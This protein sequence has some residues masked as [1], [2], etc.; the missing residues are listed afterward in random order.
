MKVIWIH[1]RGERAREGAR[2]KQANGNCVGDAICC[3]S[4]DER[5]GWVDLGYLQSWSEH[6]DAGE[7]WWV[8][9][10]LQ[11]WVI[12]GGTVCQIKIFVHKIAGS[13]CLAEVSSVLTINDGFVWHPSKSC[14]RQSAGQWIEK[15]LFSEWNKLSSNS[16]NSS[17]QFNSPF[18]WVIF[19]A[20]CSLD[21]RTQQ[22]KVSIKISL[23]LACALDKR[24]RWR[25]YFAFHYGSDDNSFRGF[26][27]TLIFHKPFV[28]F[29]HLRI[30]WQ[31]NINC[32]MLPRHLYGWE[33]FD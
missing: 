30:S 5:W 14:F 32:R 11:S 22:R 6:N 4:D 33:W 23:M 28:S 31:L 16:H 7:S 1:H 18:S 17:T 10:V 8:L 25:L 20:N 9:L 2:R 24:R 19:I 15:M 21:S 26:H 29:C 3:R 27:I 12:K 13:D